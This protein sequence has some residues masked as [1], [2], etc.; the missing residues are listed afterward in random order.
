M[1]Y[2]DTL[3]YATELYIDAFEKYF[4]PGI[5]LGVTTSIAFNLTNFIIDRLIK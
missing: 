2:R 4:F 1:S 5:V 3:R